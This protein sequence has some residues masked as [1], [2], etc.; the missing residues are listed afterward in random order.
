MTVATTFWAKTRREDWL[1][2]QAPSRFTITTTVTDPHRMT[3]I[4]VRPARKSLARTPAQVSD[5]MAR[6]RS[7]DTVPE[8]LFRNA[9]RRAGIRSFR[10]CD[11]N[12]PGKPDI[13]LPG[14]GLAIFIDG[15]FWHGHQYRA[16]GFESLDAQ[17]FGV[18]NADYW[19]LKIS[20]NI[21]RDF[22]STGALLDSGWR[23][24]RF[25]ESDI[26]KDV[27]GCVSV[28]LKA[29]HTK[30]G[31][32]A[33]SAL[34]Y[35]TAAEL[36]AGIGLVRLALDRSGWTTVFANDNDPQKFEMYRANFGPSAFDARSIHDLGAADLPTCAL[37]TASFP[38]ND[39]SLAGAR[40]GLNG[41]QSS[42][43]WGL[44]R[45]LSEMKSRRPPMVLLENVAGFLTSH[46]GKDFE[47]ALQALNDLGYCCDALVLDA[48]DFTPQSRVRLF[49][50]AK[51]GRPQAEGYRP[52]P[53]ALRP[54]LLVDFIREHPAIKW[55]IRQLPEVRAS[56]LPLQAMLEQLD[57]HH[58]AWWNQQ[59]AEYFLNQL[60]RKH[61]LIAEHMIAQPDY[62]YGTA[63]RRIR[64]GKSMAEL[65]VDGIAGCLRTPRGGSGRQILFK[66][67][68]G[69]YWVRLLTPR[70]CARLQG[71]P[72]EAYKI[73][74]RDNQAL[75]GFGDAVCVPAIQWIAD[76]YLT[77]LAGELM[78]G[79]T[80]LPRKLRN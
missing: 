72:D 2:T 60:S 38:C 22:S 15:D 35:R 63:F 19:S 66:A 7:Q 79:R 43:F 33:F 80:L 69:G 46:G 21:G 40:A 13:V 71:V 75:F 5:I 29:L 31:T 73:T 27:E 70:E 6:V 17:L 52:T 64:H 3:T 28:T 36:F 58:P 53:S 65:R 10:A 8:K 67:G 47:S 78:R 74:G 1:L 62:S 23:V 26:R 77:P 50:V 30:S 55:D 49:V 76:N 44:I 18:R 12:L 25:W 32:A 16:R 57:E 34:P 59:R 41:A 4:P 9:L 20:K 11:A 61:R 48:A 51:Q 24:L 42:T 56:R 39:L 68:R 37:I 14:K 45:L 54:K